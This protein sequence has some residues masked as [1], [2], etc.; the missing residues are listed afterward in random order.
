MKKGHV[1]ALLGTVES[2]LIG[3][4]TL[5]INAPDPFIPADDFDIL[6]VVQLEAA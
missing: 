2:V 3:T 1:A 5:V 4:H 6:I